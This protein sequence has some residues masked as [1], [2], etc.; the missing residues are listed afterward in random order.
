MTALTAPTAEQIAPGVVTRVAPGQL[1][2]T[3]KGLLA[4]SAIALIASIV[5][6]FMGHDAKVGAHPLGLPHPVED[7]SDRACER[8]DLSRAEDGVDHHV[9]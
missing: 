3:Q 6:M 5:P 2:G 4:V 1:D 8:A 9:G 7:V